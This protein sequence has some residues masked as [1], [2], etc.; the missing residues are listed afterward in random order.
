MAAG[1]MVVKGTAVT[2]GFMSNTHASLIMETV[3]I[4]P[5]AEVKDIKGENNATTTTLYSDPG[6]QLVLEGVV[7]AAGLATLQGLIKGSAVTVNTVAYRVEDI[8]IKGS[9]EEAK[10]TLTLVKKDSMTH[11]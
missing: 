6:K 10:A 1:D 9:K 7:I 8:S 2:V 5:T 4:S 3:D 11:S